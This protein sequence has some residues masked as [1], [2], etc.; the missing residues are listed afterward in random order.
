MTKSSGSQLITA[1]PHP[2]MEGF[3]GE[4]ARYSAWLSQQIA[5]GEKPWWWIAWRHD[6]TGAEMTLV[7]EGRWIPNEMIMEDLADYFG[8]SVEELVR[9]LQLERW[10]RHGRSTQR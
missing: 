10:Y 5:A 3:G 6:I 2:S 7:L 8:T 1:H 4:I 9:S